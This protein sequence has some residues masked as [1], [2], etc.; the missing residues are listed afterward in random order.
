[1]K[2]NRIFILFVEVIFCALV[3]TAQVAQK[4]Y[5]KEY[6][7]RL[8]KTP[9][10][11]VALVVN[12][13]GS[14]MTNKDGEF[15]LQFR[16]LKPGAKVKIE[17]IYKDGY[18]LLNPDVAAQWYISKDG[19]PYTLVMCLSRKIKE[20]K[21]K[22]A[23]TSSK[24]YA[25]QQKLEEEQLA[26]ERREG[27]I[28]E[29]EYLKRIE[30]IKNTYAQKMEDIH[31]Y[32]E[33]FAR[34]DL[35]E[36]SSVEANILELIQDGDID[37]AIKKYDELDIDKKL[38]IVSDKIKKEDSFIVQIKEEKNRDIVSRDSLFQMFMRSIN[39]RA[40]A[41][42]KENFEAIGVK[43]KERA[44]DDTTYYRSAKAYGEYC[45]SQKMYSEAIKY[46]SIAERH[47]D[48][49][50]T[51]HLT[52]ILWEMAN[53]QHNLQHF[54]EA[55]KLYK[56]TIA[57]SNFEEEKDHGSAF[58]QMASLWSSMA[59]NYFYMGEIDSCYVHYNLSI[60]A[61]EHAA[62]NNKE[63]MEF[64]W[65]IRLNLANT[66]SQLNLHEE[67]DSIYNSVLGHFNNISSDSIKELILLA[68]IGLAQSKIAQG[69]YEDAE[70]PLL[71]WISAKKEKSRKNPLANEDQ[72][73]IA[74]IKLMEI[75]GQTKQIN[76]L[77]ELR[78]II[79]KQFDTYLT[80]N[81]ELYRP[82]YATY[83][84]SFNSILL[85]HDKNYCKYVIQSMSD[86][87]K[88]L[89][90]WE[91]DNFIVFLPHKIQCALSIG[92]AC[93][94]AG[95]MP[96]FEKWT[97]KGINL[98]DSIN[99][100]E[101]PFLEE[102]LDGCY[103]LAQYYYY[104]DNNDEAEIYLRRFLKD[105]DYDM[106]KRGNQILSSFE[107]LEHISIKQG[108]LENALGCVQ[109]IRILG[110]EIGIHD[111]D[112]RLYLSEAK[113]LLDLKRIKE[114]RAAYKKAEKSDSNYVN[115]YGKEL[116]ELIYKKRK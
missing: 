96:E 80:A 83:K 28:K 18:E 71:K 49:K 55:N 112:A 32:F 30:E 24:S 53:A 102:V 17:E 20:L 109:N 99:T 51:G 88:Q 41:G 78:P 5:V 91:M 3:T 95:D 90:E 13:A 52:A 26:K 110:N 89:Q 58:Y 103:N 70:E 29:T 36:L 34:I 92:I 97:K 104:T 85:N 1:M 31:S 56:K 23:N 68:E 107:M 111:K 8:Q 50:E 79:D 45:T 42:G 12:N 93:S 37:S 81:P 72:V 43:L 66:Y 65:V 39:T 86:L 115:Q 16:T 11:N 94:Q 27:R 21:D 87:Y 84:I 14:T 57:C 62:K 33:K 75:Y 48:K 6:N 77:N 74:Q 38:K 67:A 25:R 47:I 106:E 4:G 19:Q 108:K 40:M 44:D 105:S 114:A 35:S 59:S 113:I 76:K 9:L 98:L 60:N 2:F 82:L 54:A 73:I 116:Y 63:Y 69:H 64:P 22:Y 10:E 46:L 61:A 15:L 100:V 7:G 101:E